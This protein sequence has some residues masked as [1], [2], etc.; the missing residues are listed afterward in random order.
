MTD[1]NDN[2]D[3]FDD[4][5]VSDIDDRRTR[6]E[7]HG[8]RRR[9]TVQHH[10]ETVTMT[11]PLISVDAAPFNVITVETGVARHRRQTDDNCNNTVE[12]LTFSDDY[13]EGSGNSHM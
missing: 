11:T 12:T 2:I 9:V 10:R 8:R 13:V 3:G 6:T 5:D 4:D 7:T 1:D